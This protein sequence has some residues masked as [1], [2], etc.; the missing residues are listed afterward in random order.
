ME[1]S[2]SLLQ[3]GQQCLNLTLLVYLCIR[4]VWKWKG[5]RR[6]TLAD[7][8]HLLFMLGLQSLQ[9][10]LSPYQPCPPMKPPLKQLSHEEN[11]T[12]VCQ[13]KFSY[14]IEKGACEREEV[15]STQRGLKGSF[16][17]Q[18]FSAQHPSNVTQIPPTEGMASL[19]SACFRYI[20]C[21]SLPCMW[22]VAF[23]HSRGTAGE[24]RL[25]P[26][27]GCFKTL[28]AS[29][30]ASGW[31]GQARCA[32]ADFEP[33]SCKSTHCYSPGTCCLI[34]SQTQTAL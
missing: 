14:L 21:I 2:T 20:S 26:L 34:D 24:P 5:G 30:E 6:P 10:Q 33:D 18:L 29:Q 25:L 15:V 7:S 23:K 9:S 16:E 22:C 31:P 17:S 3:A 1:R 19:S 13:C 8:C 28:A 12:F 32:P 4:D 11:V 27:A